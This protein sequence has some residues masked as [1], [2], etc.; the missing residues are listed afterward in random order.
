MASPDWRRAHLPPLFSDRPDRLPL[1]RFETSTFA[2]WPNAD[3]MTPGFRASF[4]RT[5][6]GVATATG[7]LNGIPAEDVQYV[8]GHAD[9]RTKWLYDRRQKQVTRNT[10]ERMSF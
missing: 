5:R 9:W 6:S 8:L 7:L 4:R 1:S 2:G 10:V 3:Y